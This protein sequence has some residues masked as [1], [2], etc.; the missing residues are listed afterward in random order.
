VCERFGP[1]KNCR[2]AFE[3]D[4]SKLPYLLVLTSASKKLYIYISKKR[5][6][7]LE[8]FIIQHRP[9]V[10]LGFSSQVIRAREVRFMHPARQL[11]AG[12]SA[13]PAGNCAGN[14]LKPC[15]QLCRQL[16]ETLQATLQAT[17]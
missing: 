7:P 10:I 3:L 1:D 9:Y 16:S 14:S 2:R 11:S 15:R 4:E 13:D 5:V 12:N 6:P 17:L 8:L